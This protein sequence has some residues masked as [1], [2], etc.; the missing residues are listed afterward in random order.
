M[1][2]SSNIL[3]TIQYILKHFNTTNEPF[4]SVYYIMHVNNVIA[5]YIT[6]ILKA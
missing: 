3:F 6:L 2:Y 4:V 1:I 5:H